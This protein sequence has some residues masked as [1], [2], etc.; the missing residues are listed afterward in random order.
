MHHLIAIPPAAL[1]HIIDVEHCAIYPLRHFC[2]KL[3]THECQMDNRI[4]INLLSA[5]HSLKC[6][7]CL[8]YDYREHL[9]DDVHP[10]SSTPVHL[11]SYQIMQMRAF[12][13]AAYMLCLGLYTK[14]RMEENSGYKGHWPASTAHVPHTM[15][16][17]VQRSTGH[18]P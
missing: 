18:G 9:D 3:S 12:P 14:C 16:L 17:I 1:H 4:I 11:I 6:N 13:Y 10:C 15:G 5:W 8:L 2:M 7:N